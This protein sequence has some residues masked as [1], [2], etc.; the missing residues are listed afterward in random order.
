M[1]F[2]NDTLVKA[3]RSCLIGALALTAAGTGLA[4]ETD[5]QTLIGQRSPALV[6]IKF[7]LKVKMGGMM[8]SMGDS[9]NE[10]EITGVMIRPDGLVLCSNTQL[11]GTAGMMRRVLGS[12]GE[13]TTTPTDLK[14]LI[15]DDTE[16]VEAEL[17]ARDTELDLA[18]V[19]IKQPAAQEYAH[20][21]FAAAAEP[22]LGDRLLSLRRM[23]KYFDRVPIVSEAR[24][25]AVTRKPR[26]L[27]V[28]SSTLGALGLPA[29]TA[30]GKV[31][32]VNVLQ[33]P[34]TSDSSSGPMGMLSSVASME[35]MMTGLILPASEVVRAT[36]R[37]LESAPPAAT[38]QSESE[39]GS[40]AP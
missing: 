6:T 15:G 9:E 17:V 21:D 37:A 29:F 34:E 35:E 39:P 7:V 16:G 19:R 23:G 4:Q 25:A 14:V 10:Q 1:A 8:A 26:P 40:R 5:F 32:G 24:V 20:V 28:P 2:R 3:I 12:L 36:Q 31:V 11:G 38:A 33:M 18:W 30:D 27:L 22:K 13:V